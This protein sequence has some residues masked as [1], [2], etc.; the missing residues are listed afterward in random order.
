M[1]CPQCRSELPDDAKYCIKCGYDF[2]RIKTPPSLKASSD[3]LDDIETS[4]GQE[5]ETSS[6]NKG[7][8]FANRYEILDDGKKG[9]MGAV[10]K[11]KDTKLHEVVALKI[12]H[13]R[14]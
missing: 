11:V 8:L 6:F 1:Y 4:I 2:S 13:P 14:C 12:I 3:P 10:Y 7:T 5:I 9:G